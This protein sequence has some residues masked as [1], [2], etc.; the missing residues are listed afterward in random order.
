[1]W[2]KTVQSL[3]SFSKNTAKKFRNYLFWNKSQIRLNHFINQFE[4]AKKS[5]LAIKVSSLKDQ[6]KRSFHVAGNWQER[7]QS[8]KNEKNKFWLIKSSKLW[9]LDKKVSWNLF[10]LV[11]DWIYTNK[12][13]LSI[14]THTKKEDKSPKFKYWLVWKTK[15][16]SKMNF[17]PFKIFAWATW[18][19]L[20]IDKYC[21]FHFWQMIQSGSPNK[22]TPG[23][24]DKQRRIMNWQRDFT[25]LKRNHLIF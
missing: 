5:D 7:I 4:W 18:N 25:F 13:R 19:L 2:P 15:L 23:C 10:L 3:T 8:E 22:S 1:M 21:S 17:F 6:V 12:M 24:L 9:T 11:G 14:Y 16:K 20:L